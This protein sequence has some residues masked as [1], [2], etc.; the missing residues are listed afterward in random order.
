MTPLGLNVPV[1]RLV[2]E[3]IYTVII[4]LEPVAMEV[5]RLVTNIILNIPVSRKLLLSH[6]SSVNFFC[7]S[8][9]LFA[10]CYFMVFFMFYF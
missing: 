1:L 9:I 8:L 10:L 3:F 4:R 6:F 7:L 5:K 2:Y